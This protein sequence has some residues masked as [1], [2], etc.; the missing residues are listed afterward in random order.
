[1]IQA[2][3][4]GEIVLRH[5]A[6]CYCI[7][8]EP[9][10]EY[11]WHKWPDLHLGGLTL[12]L[13]P[14]KHVIFLVIA[15]L[16][17]FLTMWYAGGGSSVDIAKARDR[18]G[19]AAWSKAWCCGCGMISRSP[20]LV[21]TARSSLPTSW[22]CFFHSV[23]QP[24]RA[25]PARL[26]AHRQHCRHRGARDHGLPDHRDQRSS[27]ARPQGISAYDFSQASRAHWSRRRHHVRGDGTDRDPGEAREAVRL[28]LCVCSGT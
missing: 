26:D 15:A 18:S 17:V 24:A 19:S 9:F 3:D 7:G 11:S 22:H 14:T 20:I 16:L 8:I 4:I 27:Q 6:D 2:P 12:N 1:M 21:T 10:F 13:T 25:V 5:A 23:L 28:G